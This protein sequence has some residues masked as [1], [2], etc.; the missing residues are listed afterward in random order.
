[1]LPFDIPAGLT[2]QARL[3]E[4]WVS[5]LDTLPAGG[6]LP[7]VRSVATR[8]RVSPATVAA[9]TRA[10][11]WIGATSP[12]ITLLAIRVA[13]WTACGPVPTPP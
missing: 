13:R 8:L 12:W 6:A 9:A 5:W 11:S 4:P 3:G 7:P 10:W 1:M 2:A